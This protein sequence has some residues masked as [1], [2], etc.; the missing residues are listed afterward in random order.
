MALEHVHVEAIGGVAGDML[1]AALID[2]GADEQQIARVL[3]SLDEPGLALHVERVTVDGIAARYVRSIPPSH[4]QH[5]HDH[6]HGHH[7]LE[8]VLAVID[9]AVATPAARARAHRIFEILAAAEAVVHGGTAHDV[10]L[11]EVA[12]LDSILDVLGISVALDLLGNPS[13]SAAP[14]PSGRGKVRTSHGPLDCPVPAV[15]EISR[16]FAIPL[17][18]APVE[19]ETVTPTGIAV[20][21]EAVRPKSA[22]DPKSAERVGVGAGTK[23]FP[24]RPNVGRLYG[25]TRR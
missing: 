11:H 15:V 8:D 19:G 6:Q 18:D 13:L 2:L 4:D 23:R 10:H 3:Q 20:L 9:R 22:R 14:L 21:A 12:E 5:H 1:L 7:H 24:G 25:W 17:A 16:R